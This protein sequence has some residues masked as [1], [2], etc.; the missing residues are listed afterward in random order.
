MT[1]LLILNRRDILNPASGGAE[2]YTHEIFKRLSDDFKVVHFSAAFSGSIGE[3]LID[4]I[5]YI[6]R[7]CELTTHIWGFFYALKHRGR[8]NII[9]DQFNGAGFMTFSFK[10]S[11]MLIHQLYGDFW[12]A[13]LGA[14]GHILKSLELFL[15]RLYNAK[16]VVTV[17]ESTKADLISNGFDDRKILIVPNGTEQKGFQ[18]KKIF[19]PVVMYLGRLAITKN[20]EHAIEAFLLAKQKVPELVMYVVGDGEERQ[21]LEDRYKDTEGLNFLGY[22]SGDLKYEFLRKASVLIV[23]SIREGWGQV[24]IEA[25]MAGTP[26]VGYN[27][28]GLRDSVLNR[29]TGILVPRG[30]IAALSDRIIELLRDRKELERLSLNAMGHAK[31]FSWAESAK[32][33]EQ[34]LVKLTD[35]DEM[36]HA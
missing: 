16:T 2:I 11:M 13:K 14:L 33:M 6:R 18:P 3:E 21:R 26:V 17:S 7:G 15:L 30:D 12:H 1:K 28:E 23:P 20:P 9:I 25:N 35:K 22:V 4:G 34:L 36:R 32:A 31:K 24:V 8:F 10:N 29:E 5:L 27:V 19:E